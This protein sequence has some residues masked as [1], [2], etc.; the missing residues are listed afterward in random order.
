MGINYKTSKYKYTIKHF[1]DNLP[2]LPVRSIYLPA[3]CESWAGRYPAYTF[4]T[5]LL[6]WFCYAS[7]PVESLSNGTLSV[8]DLLLLSTCLLAA[9]SLIPAPS[10][11]LS[12]V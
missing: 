5:P 10:T 4:C 12:T 2:V 3:T 9:A 8:V 6:S 1:L 11:I 7:M